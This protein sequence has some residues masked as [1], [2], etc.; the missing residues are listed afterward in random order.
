MKKMMISATLLLL[1]TSSMA[2]KLAMNPHS[3]KAVRGSHEPF[4]LVLKKGDD[5]VKAITQC[6]KDANIQGATIMGLGALDHVTLNYFDHVTKHYTKSKHKE[7][8]ELLSLNGNIT[9]VHNQLTLH[10]HS[11]LSDKQFKLF[12][13]HMDNARVAATAEIV[14]QPLSTPLIKKAD[15]LT[16]LELIETL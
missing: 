6:A 5:V 3:C 4:M 2:A 14:V 13:G 9:R 11:V 15:K 16:G 8:L 12:G 1:S 10:M 7:F